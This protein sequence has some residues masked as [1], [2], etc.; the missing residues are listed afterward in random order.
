MNVFPLRLETRYEWPTQSGYARK[1]NER[2]AKCKIERSKIMSSFKSHVLICRYYTH[3]HTHIELE[4]INEFSKFDKYKT[5]I[6]KSVVC[7]CFYIL[8]TNKLKS[9][10]RK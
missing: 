7:L 10:L 1:R 8:T 6:P 4:L 9:K 2:H 5:N 3:T